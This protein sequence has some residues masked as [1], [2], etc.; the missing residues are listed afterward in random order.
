MEPKKRI[1]TPI[2]Q[3]LTQPITLAG[4]ARKP[5]TVLFLGAAC[6][7]FSGLHWYTIGLTAIVVLVGGYGLRQATSWNSHFYTVL[8]R[9]WRYHHHYG[10]EARAGRRLGIFP[11]AAFPGAKRP[12]VPNIRQVEL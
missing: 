11:S 3:S 4:M 2:H 1:G 5:A 12:A 7:I 8:I 6:L 9:Y 10:A